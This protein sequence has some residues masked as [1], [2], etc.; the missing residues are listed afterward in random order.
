M[1]EK[2]LPF[3]VSSIE[4]D[5]IYRMMAKRRSMGYSDRDLSFLLGYRA[6]YVQDIENPLKTLRYTAKDTNYLL[7]I[8]DCDLQEV[9]TGKIPEE[10][11]HITVET[12]TIGEITHFRIFKEDQFVSPFLTVTI[13]N[14]QSIAVDMTNAVKIEKFIQVL[15][16]GNFFSS[17]RTA[18]E[19]F[20]QCKQHFEE[21]VHPYLLCVAIGKYTGKRKAPRLIQQKNNSSRTVYIKEK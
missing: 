2:S 16:D 13:P 17:P 21:P 12:A 1:K 6:L 14:P 3:P 18:L 5:K 7:S 9:M 20:G 11:Y 4:F 10:F 19:I 15:F 8:F